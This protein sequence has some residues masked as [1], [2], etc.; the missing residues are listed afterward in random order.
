[1]RTMNPPVVGDPTGTPMDNAF[2]R[3]PMPH[4]FRWL[5]LDVALVLATLALYIPGL[6]WSNTILKK[7]GY[8]SVDLLTIMFVPVVGGAVAV[9]THWRYCAREVYWTPL[10]STSPVPPMA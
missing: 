5:L 9:R 3:L 7:T 8:R 4:F 10:P 2:A 6:V 1:M